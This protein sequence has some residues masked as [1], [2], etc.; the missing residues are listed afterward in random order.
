M[1]NKGA[2]NFFAIF[3]AIISLFH[4]SFTLKTY[5]V[6]KNA[7]EA[8]NYDNTDLPQEYRDSLLKVYKDSI[9]Y[10]D[11][12]NILVKKYNYE[13][14][15]QR[16]INL[17]LDLQGGMHVTLEV[18][19][20]DLLRELSNYSKDPQF[21]KIINRAKEMQ[22]GGQEDFITYFIKAHR[23]IIPDK[24]LNT[25]FS[26]LD[27][28]GQVDHKT[29]DEDVI[30]FLREN[31]E[32]SLN[33]AFD[34]LKR[35][36]DKFGVAQPNIQLLEGSGRI[37]VELPG[38][39]DPERIKYYLQSTAKL[40]FWETYENKEIIPL[41]EEVNKYL[42]SYLGL[43]DEKKSTADSTSKDKETLDFLET[44]ND[45]NQVAE[46][47]DE[48]SLEFLADENDT[49]KVA[50]DSTLAEDDSTKTEQFDIN[51]FPLYQVLTPYIGTNEQGG[52]YFVDGP[53][54]GTA[55]VNDTPKVNKYLNLPQVK[56]LLLDDVK[57]AW[58]ANAQQTDNGPAVQLIALKITTYDQTAPLDGKAVTR[59]LV[60]ISPLGER[61]ITL[62]MN[63][64]GAETWGQPY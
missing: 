30:R 28:K 41:F 4:L 48:S 50:A 3:L 9:R 58:T 8:V 39:D 17:G 7:K 19:M 62:R 63:N 11:V 36:I 40:E 47:K 24:D 20:D 27:N 35:R 26:T 43:N 23:E 37:V 45:T 42:V 5:L 18:A 29:S 38:V 25:Y 59:A 31:A 22:K 44:D 56:A 33:S 21:Q 61:E 57:F 15:K 46:E 13:E 16:E 1:K 52:Q 32:S 6:E 64:E 53:I 60:N 10:K 12:Y 55:F 2:V 49:T 14:I 51:D 54:I 34:V